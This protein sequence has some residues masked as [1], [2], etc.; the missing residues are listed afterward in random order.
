MLSPK[1]KSKYSINTNKNQSYGGKQ[2]LWKTLGTS[3]TEEF[4]KQGYNSK[5]KSHKQFVRRPQNW[6][7][8]R[9]FKKV[10]S[11]KDKE[12]AV[13]HQKYK[14]SKQGGNYCFPNIRKKKKETMIN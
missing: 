1:R 13:R 14:T 9:H 7:E 8:T 6:G 10:E 11:L 2:N 5:H 3:S 4:I 12:A